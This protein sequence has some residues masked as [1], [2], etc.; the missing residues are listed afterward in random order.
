[1]IYCAICRA[2]RRL[3]LADRR[4][5]EPMPVCGPRRLQSLWDT[6]TARWADVPLLMP[7]ALW[8]AESRAIYT[9]AN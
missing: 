6:K 9:R 1:M 8:T 7:A 4:S 2:E 3:V 5:D